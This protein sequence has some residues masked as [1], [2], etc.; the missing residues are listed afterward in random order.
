MSAKTWLFIASVITVV[1]GVAAFAILGIVAK[2]PAGEYWMVV[3]GGIVV[4]G[5]W[6]ALITVLH[7][8]SLRE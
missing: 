7:R 1:F 4:G 5:A 6:L 8:Q 3:L 2:V